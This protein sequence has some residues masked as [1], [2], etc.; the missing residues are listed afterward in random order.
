MAE[1]PALHSAWEQAL[2]TEVVEVLPKGQGANPNPCVVM[3][4]NISS[5]WC[6]GAAPFGGILFAMM[7]HSGQ[8]ALQ[9]VQRDTP[10]AQQSHLPDPL[11]TSC[12]FLK[13][14]RYG[15]VVVV[16]TVN[17]LSA[18]YGSVSVRLYQAKQ[19]DL[20]SHELISQFHRQ[21]D[22]FTV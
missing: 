18:K 13:K 8:C 11:S 1:M 4:C 6:V 5:A 10:C 17:K 3:L 19:A 15:P 12:Q 21:R 7:T 22:A 16:A 9:A 14:C 20:G 2:A